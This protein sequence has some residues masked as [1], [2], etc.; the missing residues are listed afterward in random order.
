MINV[1]FLIS[2]KN[3]KKAGSLNPADNKSQKD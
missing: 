2:G 1:A 3:I